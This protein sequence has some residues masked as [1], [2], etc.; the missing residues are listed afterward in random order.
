LIA[1]LIPKVQYLVVTKIN[2][3][4][5]PKVYHLSGNL[6]FDKDA[7]TI[8]DSESRFLENDFTDGLDIIVKGSLYNDGLYQIAASSGATAGVLTLTTEPIADEDSDKLIHIQ[9]IQFPPD[10]SMAAAEYIA[11]KLDTKRLLKSV[12]FDDYSETRISPTE[13]MQVF[14]PWRDINVS[15]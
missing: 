13:I 12:R 6:T 11:Q 7:K 15:V 14:S 3:F 9:A 5:N 2:S 4:L 10:I 1:L 8:T